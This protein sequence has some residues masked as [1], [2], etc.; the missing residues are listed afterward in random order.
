MSGIRS[1]TRRAFI[2]TTA[3]GISLYA[4]ETQLLS[5][6]TDSA[7]GSPKRIK[8]TS[9]RLKRLL[10]EMDAKGSQYLSVPR[11]DGEFLHLIVK[12]VRSKR[13]LEIGTSQGFS[14]IW[15]GLALEETDG[16]L[17]SIMRDFL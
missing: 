7:E 14:A 13:V 2:K 5:S 4:L 10:E 16:Q 15:M 11:K 12:A 17:T 8:S 1:Y 9:P 6:M 3:E